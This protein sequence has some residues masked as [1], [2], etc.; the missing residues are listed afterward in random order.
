MKDMKKEIKEY[1]GKSCKSCEL[2]ATCA[3]EIFTKDFKERNW[4]CCD[5]EPKKKTVKLYRY[6]YANDSH[7]VFQSDWMSTAFG[8]YCMGEL[9]KTEEKE[10]EV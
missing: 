2:K 10:V 5:Y 7:D 1:T 8:G 9:L 4:Y 3:L 6:T